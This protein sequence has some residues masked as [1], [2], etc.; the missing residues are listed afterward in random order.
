MTQS[1]DI[2]VPSGLKY[3][4]YYLRTISQGNFDS[5]CEAY[6]ILQK[7]VDGAYVTVDDY[8]YNIPYKNGMYYNEGP[9]LTAGDWR[10]TFTATPDS[11]SGQKA[12]IF[13]QYHTCISPINMH[14]VR[15][16]W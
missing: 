11:T 9:F 10:L 8:W 14:L 2:S 16:S 1:V 12:I 6:I 13:L 15:Y 3:Q 7:K 5:E 4:F